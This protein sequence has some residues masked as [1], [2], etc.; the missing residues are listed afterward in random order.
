MT[1][2]RTHDSGRAARIAGLATVILGGIASAMFAASCSSRDDGFDNADQRELVQEGGAAIPPCAEVYCSRDLKKVLGRCDG[3]TETVLEE[4]GADQGC[5]AGSCV[6]PCTSA[7]LSK[8]STG[9]S[10]WTMPA[11]DD[12]IGRGSCFA[13]MVSNTWDRPVTLTASFDGQPLS[14][15]ES[16]YTAETDSSGVTHY[17]PLTG[18]LPVGQVAI[19]FLSQAPPAGQSPTA[20]TTCPEGVKP[21]LALDPLQHS[22]G[23]T[24]AFHITTDAPVSAYSIFPYGGAASFYPSATLLLPVSA[25]GTNY[26]AVSP[27]KVIRSGGQSMGNPNPKATLQ[28]VADEDDTEIRIRPRADITEGGGASGAAAGSV[29]TWKLAKGQVLQIAQLD[30]LSGSP[31]E[32]NK[33]VGMFG[34][35]E[36]SYVPTSFQACD[37]LRQQIPPLT[38]W[39]S[40][41]ALVPFRPRIEAA[42]GQPSR[43]LVPWRIVGAVDNTHLTYDPAPPAGAPEWLSAGEVV[44]F[45]TDALVVVKS[46]DKDHPFYSGVFMTGALFNGT[47]T[48]SVGTMIIGETLGDPDFVNVAPSD[49]F[50]DHYV[51]F[52]DN[53]YPDTSITIVRRKSAGVFH[54]VTLGCAGEVTGFQPLGST[55]D[56]EFAWV[57]LTRASIPRTF[58]AGSCGYGRHEARSDG[59]FSVTVWGMAKYASYGYAGG[60]GS[61]PINQVVSPVVR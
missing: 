50:L 6:D 32:S 54:P 1:R 8:G 46:Q 26:V 30:D 5:G 51:F 3:K 41:Y 17:Q 57:E 52:A 53:T 7:A 56:Y 19:V 35:A 38:Q 13:T 9:C 12:E 23:I 27:G 28:L 24:R 20:F 29:Q 58:G 40:E 48:S 22:T 36:C 55:G 21:A 49:Q 4:C 61:R 25:W 33:P 15:A 42:G 31:I 45:M 34:G 59:P 39:G 2:E 43:E 18:P 11:E 60:V 14:I 37:I 16:A 47:H 44:N 10:F